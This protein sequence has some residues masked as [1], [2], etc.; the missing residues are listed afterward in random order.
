LRLRFTL[1]SSPF[2]VLRPRLVW[3]TST[4]INCRQLH[5]GL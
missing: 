5:S 4:G 3:A 2:S 1:L